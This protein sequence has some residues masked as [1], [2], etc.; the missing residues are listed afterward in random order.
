[1]SLWRLPRQSSARRFGW[2]SFLEVR[3]FLGIHSQFPVTRLYVQLR[4]LRWER[5][6]GAVYTALCIGKTVLVLQSHRKFSTSIRSL[7]C[8]SICEYKIH[9]RSGETERPSSTGFSILVTSVIFPV[10]KL[11]N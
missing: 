6:S 10:A 9:F 11:K 1:V 4:T 5:V 7:L 3:G 8:S 2:T